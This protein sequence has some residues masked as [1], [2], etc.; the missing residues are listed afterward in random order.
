MGAVV[1]YF[2]LRVLCFEEFVCGNGIYKQICSS[3]SVH[4]FLSLLSL[5]CA[6]E[7]LISSFIQGSSDRMCGN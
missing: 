5:L 1:I 2:V 7:I 3:C 4:I 6:P